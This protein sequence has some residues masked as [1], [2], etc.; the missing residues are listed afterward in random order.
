MDAD[1][2]SDLPYFSVQAKKSQEQSAMFEASAPLNNDDDIH[3]ED[4]EDTSKSLLMIT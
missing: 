3:V 1:D 2:E 4:W